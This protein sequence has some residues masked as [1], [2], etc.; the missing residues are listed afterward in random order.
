MIRTPK[1][2]KDRRHP[3]GRGRSS[4]GEATPVSRRDP[5][6]NAEQGQPGD[7]EPNPEPM[8]RYGDLWRNMTARWRVH[9]R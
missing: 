5:L 9:Q 3:V 1:N 4:A 8:S 6:R 2:S 7:A